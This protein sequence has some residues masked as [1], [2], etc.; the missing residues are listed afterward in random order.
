MKLGRINRQH[1]WESI[2]AMV[3]I[4]ATEKGDSSR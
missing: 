3:K 4:G 1:L 2:M